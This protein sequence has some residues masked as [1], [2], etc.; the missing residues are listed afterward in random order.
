TLTVIERMGARVASL[1]PDLERLLANDDVLYQ[2]ALA[3]HA[4]APARWPAVEVRLLACARSATAR[5]RQAAIR[6]LVRWSRPEGD[7]LQLLPEVYRRCDPE[8][9]D[10]D[11][12]LIR[13]LCA[14]HELAPIVERLVR[15]DL[16]QLRLQ[17]PPLLA[18]LC[19]DRAA[20]QPAVAWLKA[21]FV[22]LE[23]RMQRSAQTA[24]FCGVR[25]DYPHGDYA[26]L[27]GAAGESA[28]LRRLG[29]SKAPASPAF[30]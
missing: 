25:P 7:A 19:D 24:G 28:V 12:E 8:R 18:A 11:P 16:W 26:R 6:L 17:Q 5:S 27:L 22:G 20:L 21:Q 1:L 10:L 13:L 29:G 3:I 23:E 14:G 4:L 15:G 9:R 2:T 30:A